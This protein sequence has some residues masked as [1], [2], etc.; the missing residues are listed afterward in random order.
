MRH[1]T[2]TDRGILAAGAA[3][4]LLIASAA[5]VGAGGTLQFK[6][7]VDLDEGGVGE[8][9]I[10]VSSLVCDSG[11]AF[12]DFHFGTGTPTSQA[13]TFHLAKLIDCG[14][15][16]TFWIRLDAASNAVTGMGTVG[17][18]TVIK[19]SGTGDLAGIAGGGNIVGE[20]GDG[21]PYDLIDHYYGVLRL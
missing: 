1:R 9:V 5:P 7:E 3:L 19:G 2:A 6:I 4:L 8:H 20:P 10:G 18:W 17:G 12:T 11:E 13:F 15:G 21:E 16:N 14:D